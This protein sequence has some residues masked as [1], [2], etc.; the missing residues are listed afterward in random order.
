MQIVGIDIMLLLWQVDWRLVSYVEVH[1][2]V[3]GD[4]EGAMV[5]SLELYVLGISKGP[6]ISYQLRC[7]LQFI[8]YLPIEKKHDHEF[9]NSLKKMG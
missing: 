6:H 4:V 2:I 8:Q 3:L 9:V 5:F 1:D 7:V